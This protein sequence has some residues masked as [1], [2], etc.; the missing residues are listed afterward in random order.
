MNEASLWPTIQPRGQVGAEPSSVGTTHH[1]FSSPTERET[2]REKE[3]TPTPKAKLEQ[4]GAHVRLLQARLADQTEGT[5]EYTK[6]LSVL[7]EVYAEWVHATA[8][9]AEELSP[10]REVAKE[11][12][13][14]PSHLQTRLQQLGEQVD[15]L[16]DHLSL[17]EEGS[18]EYIETQKELDA[19]YVQWLEA[20]SSEDCELAS[21]REAGED[22]Q[23]GLGEQID[24]LA[25]HMEGLPEGSKERLESE[26]L[27][28][29]LLNMAGRAHELNERIGRLS[30]QGDRMDSGEKEKEKGIDLVLV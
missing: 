8:L 24:T 25:Q 28:E 27:M 18:E 16:R 7:D 14:E 20:R 21:M 30:V 2:E 5:Q 12:R 11:G 26:E 1:T 6:A 29:R 19:V 22:I 13:R 4:L 23:E 10:S 9:Y 3:G 17:Q 15:M